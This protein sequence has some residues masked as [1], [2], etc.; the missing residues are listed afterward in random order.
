[1]RYS[2]KILAYLFFII[3]TICFIN[4]TFFDMRSFIFESYDSSE[5]F[6]RG[7]EEHFPAGFDVDKA[8]RI[9]EESGATCTINE[10]NSDYEIRYDYKMKKKVRYDYIDLAYC[11]YESNLISLHPFEFYRIIIYGNYKREIVRFFAERT[12]GMVI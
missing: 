8:V 12:V 1:M 6:E 2:V 7:L 5:A 4:N 3:V 11:K 9:L 10:Y